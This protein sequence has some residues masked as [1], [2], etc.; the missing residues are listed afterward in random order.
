[1]ADIQSEILKRYN[2]DIAQENIFK[3]YKIDSADISPQAL[4]SKIQET[5]KKWTA[6]INGANEKNAERDRKRL[7]KAD[8]YEA[9]LKDNKLRKE[10]FDFYNKPN[11]R[12][13]GSA[14]PGGGST[15][16]AR[17]YFE[18]VKTTKKIKKVD[19]D[20]FFKYYQSEKKNK[21]AILE[22]LSKEMKI[23]GLSKE[24]KN[25]DET[26]TADEEGKKKDDAS[27]LVV[28]LFQEATILNIRKAIDFFEKA[29]QSNELC[30]RYPALKD[31]FFEFLEV[32][33]VKDAKQFTE[34][35][36][37]KS[38]EVYAI[39]QE[40]GQEYVPLVDMFNTL[41][42]I[43]DYQ[44]VVDNFPEFK[45]L[46]KFPDLTPYMFAFVE[47]KP[48][49]VEGIVKV[50]NKYYSFRDDTDFILN[51]YKPVH[52]HFGISD[53]GIGSILRK[54][55]K[56]AKQNKVLNAVDKKLGRN[57]NRRKISVGAEIIHW[58]VYWPIFAVYLVFEA[59]K[60]IFTKLNKLVIPVFVILFGLENWLLP[61]LGV[62]PYN[63]LVLRK[64][65]FKNQ[66]L[67]CLE[68]FMGSY[69]YNTLDMIVASFAVIWILSAVYI[70]PPL[71]GSQF[72]KAFADDFNKR[73]DWIGIERTFK[74]IFSFLR[75]KTEYQYTTQKK[76]FVKN[77][78]PKIIINLISLA[79]LAGIIIF[80]PTGL[81]KLSEATGYFQKED[82]YQ[83]TYS[84]YSS[85]DGYDSDEYSND[86]GVDSDNHSE[87][88]LPV[89]DTMVITAGSANIRSGPS[90]DYDVVTT[91]SKGTA[92]VAT[93]EQETASNGGIWYEIYIDDEMTQTGWASQKV[94]D[95]Q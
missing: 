68:D 76:L 87:E 45:L 81:R 35:M 26:D 95:F 19:V 34:S 12:D 8:R 23:L 57:K 58:L 27:Q 73:F 41:K 49:T 17:E 92:F 51:Y 62:L 48:A 85:E 94:V 60:A 10:V 20:F 40:R 75:E 67:S 1:M 24:G 31:S 7:E 18:L 38:K 86:D 53:G 54:A 52:D 56:K 59:A 14:S 90:T 72:V 65:F 88:N 29:S 47:M 22:M 2:I 11:G 70:L 21:K 36:S 71:F 44:D 30:Q 89:G 5:R 50:A 25:A 79:I 69:E 46:L 82:T 4:E 15:D 6:S 84:D 74:Q 28:H 64:V 91:A 93:G 33:D 37:A 3:L 80:A 32:N 66:W 78:V 39:R 63:L 16:F 55:E 61:K 77:K 9:I 83:E 43:G 42:A 13:S